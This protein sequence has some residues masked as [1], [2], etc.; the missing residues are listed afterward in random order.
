MIEKNS[1]NI[2]LPKDTGYHL[3]SNLEGWYSFAYLNGDKGGRYALMA[4][5]FRVGELEFLKGHYLI[6]TLIDLNKET[7]LNYSIID[8]KLKRNLITM[9]L[10]FY[11]LQRPGNTRMWKQ[12]KRLLFGQI[13]S[14]HY[15]MKKVT[16]KGSPTELIYG[17]NSLSFYG[18][19]EV[20]FLVHL[21]EKDTEINLQFTPAKP[22]SLI[23][24]DGKPDGLYYYSF[25]KNIVQGQIRTKKEI[26]NVKGQ[27]WF[28]HQWGR[29]YGLLTGIGWNWFGLQLNDGRELLINEWRSSKSKETLSPMANLIGT[30]GSLRFTKNV[31][32]QEMRYWQSPETQAI[33]P[34]EWQIGIPEFSMK[35]HIKAVFPNQEMPIIGPLQAIWEGTC[36]LSGQEILPNKKI[37]SLDG[38]GFMELVGYLL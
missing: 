3:F 16:I 25:T 15:L 33:Y 23:G 36:V 31:S 38:K 5:F 8:S 21:I 18:E 6:Y 11:L 7:K 10:P 29:D 22:M 2:S 28:D 14:P 26:E 19:R 24:G 1:K 30:E 13:P 32:L 17:D 12:Y 4:S 9:Y 20:S 34:I 37:S 27:G 35:L